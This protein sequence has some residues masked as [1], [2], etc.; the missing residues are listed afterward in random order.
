[1][2]TLLASL[3]IAAFTSVLACAESPTAVKALIITGD[4]D[5]SWQETTTALREILT[6]AG[7]EV[8]V[9]EEPGSYLTQDNLAAYDVLVLNYK[10]T[11]AGAKAKPESVWTLPQK[12]MVANLVKEGTGLVVLHHASSAFDDDSDWSGEYEQMIAGGRR[13]RASATEPRELDVTIQKDHPVTRGIDS[14]HHGA[15]KLVRSPRITDG[16]EVLATVFDGKEQDEPVVWVNHHGNGRVVHNLLGHDT[17]SMKGDGFAGLLVG[18]VAWAGEKGFRMIFDG[19]TLDG[20]EG[21]LRYWSVQNGAIVGARPSWTPMPVHDFLCTVEDFEDFELRIEAKVI[22][23][24]NSGICVRTN[25]Q[26]YTYPIVGYEIDMGVFRWGWIYEEGG[27]RQV[28]NRKG[29][30]ELQPKIKAVLRQ[31]D[32]NDV[33]VRCVD[34][35]IEAWINGVGFDFVETNEEIARKLRKGKIGLQLHDGKPQVV[36]F[37]N[38]RVKKLP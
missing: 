34:N 15:D 37:R 17:E 13:G 26:R 16:S 33:V 31:G 6:A 18:C 11:D 38:I 5:G 2:R 36:S 25:R 32:F 30:Q 35:R 7:H 3:V 22:G 9:T 28:L 10:P 29:Q 8:D 12:R 27:R 21:N 23:Q 24:R 19:K 20:W 1:M 14:F 4:H